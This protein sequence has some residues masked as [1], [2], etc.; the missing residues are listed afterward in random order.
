MLYWKA[1]LPLTIFFLSKVLY[2]ALSISADLVYNYPERQ[3]D[4]KGLLQLSSEHLQA[5]LMFLHG[6]VWGMP[7]W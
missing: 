2:I 7:V 3:M 5:C 6:S 4:M 1:L